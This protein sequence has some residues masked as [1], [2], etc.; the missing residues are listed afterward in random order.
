MPPPISGFDPY[1]GIFADSLLWLRSGWVDFMAPQLYW[2]VNS[3]GQ[4]YPALLDWWLQHNP[5]GRCEI[6]YLLIYLLNSA[7]VQTEYT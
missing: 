3:T 6:D 7:P 2:A 1:S 4:S 5:F